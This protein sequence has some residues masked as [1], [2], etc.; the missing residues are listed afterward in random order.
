MIR[1]I[2]EISKVH[3]VFDQVHALQDV[4]LTLDEGQ[5][6]CLLGPSGCG[7]TTLLRIVA[8]LE[9]ADMGY[10]RFAGRDLT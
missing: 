7:K 5:I 2:L 8:G 1:E 3:K 4:S 10:V 6:L 9:T